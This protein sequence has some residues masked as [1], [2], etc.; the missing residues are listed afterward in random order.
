VFQVHG[1]HELGRARL[2]NQR[3]RAKV[4]EFFAQLAGASRS[5]AAQESDVHRARTLVVSKP[6]RAREIR[7][8]HDEFGLV[9]PKGVARLRR[10]LSGIQARL[11]EAQLCRVAT[12]AALLNCSFEQLRKIGVSV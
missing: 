4:V 3:P 10:E 7:R 5:S 12:R 2:R 11:Q 6:H 9:V 8:L 1:V